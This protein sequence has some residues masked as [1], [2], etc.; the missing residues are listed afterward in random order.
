MRCYKANIIGKSNS[1]I[2]ASGESAQV[3]SVLEARDIAQW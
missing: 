3:R 1:F 2:I